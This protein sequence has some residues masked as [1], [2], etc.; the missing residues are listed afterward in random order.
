[1]CGIEK[2]SRIRRPCDRPL[3]FFLKI[4]SS[5]AA[6]NLQAHW[7][8]VHDAVVDT[9]QPMVEERSM[10]GDGRTRIG[11]GEPVFPEVNL[12]ARRVRGEIRLA[13]TELVEVSHMGSTGDGPER[14][15]HLA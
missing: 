4:G 10:I 5:L 3:V 12:L 14:H 1:M 9:L 11:F 8:L 6:A 15:L 7:R 2:P 13:A